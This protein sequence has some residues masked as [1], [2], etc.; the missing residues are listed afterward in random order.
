MK[1][2]F[3]LFSVMALAALPLVFTSC[4][5]K[6]EN[7]TKDGIAVSFGSTAWD[8]KDILGESYTG[9]MQLG[10]FKDYDDAN[11][12]YSQGYLVP[13]IGD[14]TYTANNDDYH[15]FFYYENE[16][17]FITMNGN[18][19]P[20]WQPRAG[21]KTTISAIDLTA[22]TL[23]GAVEGTMFNLEE[24]IEQNSSEG[25]TEN[26]LTITMSNANWE[27]ISSKGKNFKQMGEIAKM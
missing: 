9:I 7:N 22:L 3:R 27:V 16:D 26:T 4:G 14:V 19:Y 5:D 15:Y 24:A 21:M 25:V 13:A 12:P 11:A 18:E 8:A 10:A 23:S 20:V 1:K 17:N 2:F 6:E